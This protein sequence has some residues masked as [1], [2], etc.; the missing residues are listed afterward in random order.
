[1][2]RLTVANKVKCP[3]FPAPALLH[4]TVTFNKLEHISSSMN[5]ISVQVMSNSFHQLAVE[6]KS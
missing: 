5:T 4:T 6:V 1:M 2:Q 3:R